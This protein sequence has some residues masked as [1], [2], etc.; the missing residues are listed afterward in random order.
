MYVSM[1][2]T[3]GFLRTNVNLAETSISLSLNAFS[4]RIIE[5]I[6]QSSKLV[7]LSPSSLTRVQVLCVGCM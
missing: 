1:I 3:E 4:L 2:D 5:Y 6:K 7:E